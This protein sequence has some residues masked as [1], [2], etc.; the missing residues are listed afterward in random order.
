MT[1]PLVRTPDGAILGIDFRRTDLSPIQVPGRVAAQHVM[2]GDTIRFQG[3]DVV[4]H[5]K[6]AH[7]EPG[8]VYIGV[9]NASGAELV[10]ERRA[11]ETVDVVAVGAFDPDE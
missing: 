1:A 6:R 5:T 9:R 11:S 2:L 8:V 7:G 4:V 3:D 10:L